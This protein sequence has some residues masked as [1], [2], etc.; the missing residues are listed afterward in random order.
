MQLGDVG[1]AHGR[2]ALGGVS[3]GLVDVLS[4]PGRC[5]GRLLGLLLGDEI[6]LNGLELLELLGIDDAE[7]DEDLTETLLGATGLGGGGFAQLIHADELQLD[8]K[9]ANQRD[10]LLV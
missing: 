7:L 1:A 8:R 4:S 10:G 2:G 5:R 9:P 3:R 6:A